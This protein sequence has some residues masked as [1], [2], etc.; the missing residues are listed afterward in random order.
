MSLPNNP[1]RYSTL[2]NKLKV[3]E[4]SSNGISSNDHFNL[5]YRLRECRLKTEL[6]FTQVFDKCDLNVTEQEPNP[7]GKCIKPVHLPKC[8][9]FSWPAQQTVF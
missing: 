2:S 5:K 7:H 9:Y 3:V 6:L 4:V 8:V 1:H